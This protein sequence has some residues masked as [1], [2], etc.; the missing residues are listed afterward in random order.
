[1]PQEQRPVPLVLLVDEIA[2][3]FLT[4]GGKAEKE[5]AAACGVSL[6]RIAQLG[7]ALGVYLVAAGQRVGSDLGPGVTALR[8]QLG[9]RICH[10]VADPQTALMT[11]GD[12]NRDAAEVAQAIS[13]AEPGVAITA[14]ETG[15]WVRAKAYY[16]SPAEA[17]A[18][19]DTTVGGMP[20]VAFLR[21]GGE[22]R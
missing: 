16:T 18:V 20:Y 5:E 21:H 1:M 14:T 3:L 13:P 11:L 2:E 6:L 7:R 22:V 10:R 17:R 15:G 4:S 9:G 8:A 12:L 19:A